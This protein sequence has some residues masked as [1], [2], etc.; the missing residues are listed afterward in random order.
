MTATLALSLLAPQQLYTF[1]FRPTTNVTSVALVGTFNNW[2]KE[3]NPMKV[4]PD[5]STYT[6]SIPLKP[7]R[8]LYKF[9]LNG[10]KWIIDPAASSE[11]DGNGNVNSIFFAKDAEF[12]VPAK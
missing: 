7:G 8:Y 5:G 3:A 9:V 10:E 12:A 11:P 6:L 2:N 4:G 1:S